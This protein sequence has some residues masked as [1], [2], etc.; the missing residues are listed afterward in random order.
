[1]KKKYELKNLKT[2]VSTYYTSLG[3]LSSWILVYFMGFLTGSL[4]VY[5][6]SS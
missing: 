4:I 2:K 6:Y 1:M 3:W 5:L